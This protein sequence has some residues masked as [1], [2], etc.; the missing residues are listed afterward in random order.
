MPNV[1]KLENM[2]SVCMICQLSQHGSRKVLSQKSPKQY[3]K[4]TSNSVAK[5]N[6]G[7]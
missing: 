6:I 4:V 5:D 7:L 1:D 2:I 3:C